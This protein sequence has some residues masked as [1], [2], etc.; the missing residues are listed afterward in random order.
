MKYTCKGKNNVLFMSNIVSEKICVYL[1]KKC[2]YSEK[3]CVCV[4][5]A[6]DDV[7]GMGGWMVGVSS[8]M[9]ACTTTDENNV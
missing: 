9:Y 7:S 3:V 1:M 4:C 8:R 2:V 5:D 6:G